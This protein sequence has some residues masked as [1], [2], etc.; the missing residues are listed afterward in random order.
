M[1]FYYVYIFGSKQLFPRILLENLKELPIRL[2][3]PEE[4]QPIIKL[5]DRMLELNKKLVEMGDLQTIERQRLEEEI[6]R[7]DA[8]IDELVYK[9]YGITE[10]EK[11]I[12][13]ESFRKE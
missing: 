5:V 3:S 1:K 8:Q 6:R 7:T 4:Q 13:E 12:I 2:A 9:L 10:E 11:K